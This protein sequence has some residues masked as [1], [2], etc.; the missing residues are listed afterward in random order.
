[1]AK[2]PHDRR[3]V[4]RGD[5]VEDDGGEE[6][7]GGRAAAAAISNQTRMSPA[8]PAALPRSTSSD[9]DVNSGEKPR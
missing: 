5:P 4:E 2:K 1:M 6:H 7:L 9:A 3:K 8:P